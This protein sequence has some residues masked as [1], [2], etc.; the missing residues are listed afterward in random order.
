MPATENRVTIARDWLRVAENYAA[1]RTVGQL[2]H[3]AIMNWCVD[4][5]R[6]FNMAYTNCLGVW[7]YGSV[8]A[9]HPLQQSARALPAVN[10]GFCYEI[11]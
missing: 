3:S 4:A 1:V 9:T 8:P 6:N 7:A 5:K 2:T 10:P 11:K